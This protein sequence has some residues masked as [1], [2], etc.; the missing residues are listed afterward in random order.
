MFKSSNTS[1]IFG[2]V[3]RL[4]MVGSGVTVAAPRH[5]PRA[6]KADQ[7]GYVMLSESRPPPSAISVAPRGTYNY[8]SEGYLSNQLQTPPHVVNNEEPSLHAGEIRW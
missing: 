5:F 2:W 3:Q 7:D 4:A 1:V 8:S 6:D